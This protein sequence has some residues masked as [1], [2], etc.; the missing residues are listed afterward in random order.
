MQLITNH[1]AGQVVYTIPNT[2]TV[3]GKTYEVF[4][5]SSYG[6]KLAETIYEFKDA[7]GNWY[8]SDYNTLVE[9]LLKAEK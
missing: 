3:D 4:S 2:F 9:R 8:K 7:A 1:I 6:K 5:I